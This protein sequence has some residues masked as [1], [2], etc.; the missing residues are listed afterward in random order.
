M[1]FII[2]LFALGIGAIIIEFF[3]P[4]GGIIGILGA[5]S[6]I[7][8]VVIAFRSFGEIAGVAVLLAALIITPTLLAVYFRRFPKS[9]FGRKIIL[10]GEVRKNL[11][12]DAPD[13]NIDL[14][15]RTGT[16]MTALRPAGIVRLGDRQLSVVT[17]G[18]FLPPGITVKVVQIEGNRI[19]VTKGV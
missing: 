8:A 1:A 4:A 16:T 19:L 9:F 10:G 2:G 15:G 12:L 6:L 3:V 14:L 18:E 11:S 7:T 5:G 13:R 17:S